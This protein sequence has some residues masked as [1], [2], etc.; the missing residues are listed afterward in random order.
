M[1][2]FSHLPVS[3]LDTACMYGIGIKKPNTIFSIKSWNL[4]LY[5][6]ITRYIPTEVTE[7]Q[8]KTKLSCLQV[9]ILWSIIIFYY[10]FT[11]GWHEEYNYVALNTNLNVTLKNITFGLR[12][13]NE[14]AM[15]AFFKKEI[16]RLSCYSPYLIFGTRMFWKPGVGCSAARGV[17][18]EICA[19]R[20]AGGALGDLLTLLE[21]HSETKSPAS[22]FKSREW[23]IH[24]LQR[25]IVAG[26]EPCLPAWAWERTA[27]F[28]CQP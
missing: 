2:V 4:L 17:T 28:M 22:I 27:E 21:K 13:K 10:R 23:N 5:I 24:V 3:C 11:H 9:L 12:F 7:K 15:Y 14:A 8:N 25:D 26:A 19:R 20:H 1:A 6:P 18:A 16:I